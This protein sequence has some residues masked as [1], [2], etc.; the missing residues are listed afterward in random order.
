M[1]CLEGPH[2]GWV[3]DMPCRPHSQWRVLLGIKERRKLKGEE[4]EETKETRKGEER[5]RHNLVGIHREKENGA[6]PFLRE[7]STCTERPAAKSA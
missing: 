1:G 4:E 2:C 7:H 3:I 6:P 5:F